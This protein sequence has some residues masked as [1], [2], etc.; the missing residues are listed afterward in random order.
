MKLIESSAELIKIADP[1]LK[2]ETAGRTC[3]KS[4]SQMTEETAKKFFH[5]LVERQH[6]AMLE[7]ATFVF[8][9]TKE[10]YDRYFGF[11]F[12]NYSIETLDYCEGERYL[13]S[14]NLRAIN[15]YRVIPLLLALWDKDRDLV[16][17]PDVVN[18]IKNTYSGAT[19]IPAKYGAKIVDID[20]IEDIQ[21]HAYK[22]HKYFTFRF[23]CDRGVTH[24]IV[25][26]RPASYAQESTRYCNYGKDKFGSEIT[27]IKPADY[28]SWDKNSQFLYEH[29]IRVAEACYMKMLENDRTPQ[30]ARAILPNTLK[31]EIIMTANCREFDHFFNLRA[32]G[33]TGAPH[34]DMKK[35]ALVAYALYVENAKFVRGG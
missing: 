9:V 33:T 30:E 17:A 34:P 8:E 10:V 20:S 14:G 7:H 1:F 18:S 4:T 13:I 29:S 19:P 11:K 32:I 24:E 2:I 22:A 25:R 27:C 6:T 15:E 26:H 5:S 12:L 28:D 3:Y 23:I 16:Y 21:E 35:V 31:T